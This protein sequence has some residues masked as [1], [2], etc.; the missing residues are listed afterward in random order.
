[1]RVLSRTYSLPSRSLSLAIRNE[2]GDLAQTFKQ[3][4]TGKLRNSSVPIKVVN[5]C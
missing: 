4:S 5:G 3:Q 2:V 1:M